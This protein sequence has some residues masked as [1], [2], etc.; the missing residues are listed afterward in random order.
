MVGNWPPS[1]GLV[2]DPT[3]TDTE[4]IRQLTERIRQDRQAELERPL[5]LTRS[6]ISD[7]EDTLLIPRRGRPSGSRELPVFLCGDEDQQCTLKLVE[8]IRHASQA[9]FT[10]APHKILDKIEGEHSKIWKARLFPVNS[11]TGGELVV[12][13][14]FQQSAMPLPT[15]AH[16]PFQ[17]FLFAREAAGIECRAYDRLADLQG[18]II[19]YMFGAYRMKMPNEEEAGCLPCQ[20]PMT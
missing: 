1:L 3:P 18:G 7:F 2:L 20:T 11:S 14:I 13:K 10:N 8:P 12:L 9:V 16:N 6:P 4:G 19:P 17:D 15:A 5:A